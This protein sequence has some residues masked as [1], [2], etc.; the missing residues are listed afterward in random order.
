MAL[1]NRVDS[2]ML[3]RLLDNGREQ[4]GIYAQ[5][6]RIFDAATQFSFLFAILLLPMFSRMIQQKQDINGLVRIAQPLLLAAGLSGA[7]SCNFYKEEIISLLY[8]SHAAYSSAIFGWLMIAFVFASLNY[9]Y[10]TLLTA[11]NNLG[12][13]NIIA[14]IT[15]L[16]NVTLN[17]ILI[18][19]YQAKGAAFA[20]LVSQAIFALSQWYLAIRLLKLPWN[21]DIIIRLLGFLGI[22]LLAGYLS[23]WIP[24]WLPGFFLLLASCLISAVL[25]RL[26][27]PSEIR[28]ILQE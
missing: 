23:L 16:I 14:A 27:R 20:S 6:F 13:L 22:N 4:A 3:E 25:L 15:V 12:Q 17:L 7:I 21:T 18:P 2:V 9:L 26:I 19:R 24:G 10:G 1:F 8:D 28:R 5:S 11:N